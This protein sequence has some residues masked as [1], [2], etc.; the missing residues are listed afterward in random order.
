MAGFIASE[1]EL[2]AYG[3]GWAYDRP[4]CPINSRTGLTCASATARALVL[5]LLLPRSPQDA[6]RTRA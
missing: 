6:T 1:A 3:Y 2:Q 4:A 5:V